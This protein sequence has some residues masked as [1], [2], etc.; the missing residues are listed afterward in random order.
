MG[1][2]REVVLHGR[3]RF[4]VRR[5]LSHRQCGRSGAENGRQGKHIPEL[6]GQGRRVALSTGL[7]I[8]MRAAL[9]RPF[10]GERAKPP[11]PLAMYD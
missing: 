8:F 7:K 4:M 11:P 3:Y 6:A 10:A 5:M 9:V 1:G 2:Y